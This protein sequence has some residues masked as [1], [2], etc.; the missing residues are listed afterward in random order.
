VF[1]KPETR[2]VELVPKTFSFKIAAVDIHWHRVL[3]SWLIPTFL[4]I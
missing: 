1:T 4:N 3:W 2:N